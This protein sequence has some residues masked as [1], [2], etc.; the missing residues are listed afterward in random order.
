MLAR[1]KDNNQLIFNATLKEQL[2]KKHP[3]YALSNIIDWNKFELAFKKHYSPMMGAPAKEIRLLVGIIIL[4]HLRNLSDESVVE[5]RGE[6]LY[7]QYFCG[8]RIFNPNPPCEA[9]ELVH[10]RNR[11]GEEGMEMILQESIRIQGIGRD[12]NVSSKKKGNSGKRMESEKEVIIDTT[13]QEKNITYPTDDKLYKKI[14]VI[15]CWDLSEHFF[16]IIP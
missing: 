1:K 8:E 14:F 6:N 9:S 13:V 11:I 15:F 2:D 10:F 4:K 16:S 12:K 7:Y 3:L 5:H